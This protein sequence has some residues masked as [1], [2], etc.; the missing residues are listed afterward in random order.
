MGSDSNLP[1]LKKGIK[2]L[3]EFGISFKVI[4][5]NALIQ[6]EVDNI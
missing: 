1:V 2:V 5:K 3:K 4:E 6:K